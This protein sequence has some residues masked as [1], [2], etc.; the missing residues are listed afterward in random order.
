[1]RRSIFQGL[2]RRFLDQNLC[3]VAAG[4]VAVAVITSQLDSAHGADDAPTF[5]FLI[6]EDSREHYKG[7]CTPVSPET[8]NCEFEGVRVVS[9]S[10]HTS[11]K[12]Q[13]VLTDLDRVASSD[14]QNF[15]KEFKEN[16]QELPKTLKI[17]SDKRAESN[18]YVTSLTRF[19]PRL[20]AI[21]ARKP[22]STEEAV[23]AIRELMTAFSEAVE[24]GERWTCG[25]LAQRWE[26][27]LTRVSKN[28]WVNAP[29][30]SGLCKIM[31]VY[32][33]ER[34][35]ADYSWTL[36]ETRVSGD[37]DSPLC[38]GVDE[39]LMKPVRWSWDGVSFYKL[40]CE[41]IDWDKT[42]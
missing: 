2:L 41:Y 30:P 24:Q 28:K 4:I 1:M 5:L 15:L 20:T 31:K 42:Q 25:L 32:Q 8:V 35:A 29:T 26:V 23:A 18:P 13:D 39:E 7:F 10:G 11:K 36:T 33:L 17:P 38:K 14:P 3:I 27:K 19:L 37:T 6:S 16:C 21:C 40:P 12:I 34:G 22:K 9:P